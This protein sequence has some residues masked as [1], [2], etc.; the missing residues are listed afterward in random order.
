MTLRKRAF[1]IKL[2]QDFEIEGEI[3]SDKI[4]GEIE[5]NQGEIEENQEGIQDAEVPGEALEE[6]PEPPEAGIDGIDDGIEEISG[7]HVAAVSLSKPSSKLLGTSKMPPEVPEVSEPP[8]DHYLI[9]VTT[10]KERVEEA[11]VGLIKAA[12]NLAL[13]EEDNREAKCEMKR[14]SKDLKKWLSG[15]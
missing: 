7:D 2:L 12:G 13:A 4:E 10:A 1:I 8:E 5:E 15:K 9:A 11:R 3:M 6:V 14:A